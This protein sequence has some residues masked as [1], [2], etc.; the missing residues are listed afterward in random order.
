MYWTLVNNEGYVD[1]FLSE[2]QK[3]NITTECLSEILWIL[4]NLCCESMIANYLVDEAN[5]F[6]ILENLYKQYFIKDTENPQ[7]LTQDLLNLL[8]QILWF[9]SNILAD[10]DRS[11]YMGLVNQLDKY[12]S[13][14][15]H[16]Y[17]NQF[18]IDIWKV[19][20]WGFSLL[21]SILDKFEKRDFEPFNNFLVFYFA[22][23]N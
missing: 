20:V 1:V 23:L 7:L 8:E 17:S 19:W 12:F 22:K 13:L 14:I 2:M 10:S 3:P 4:T 5:M 9:T 21:S 18:T 16:F 6:G 15:L 11:R